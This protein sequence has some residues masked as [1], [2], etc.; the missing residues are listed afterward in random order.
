M[1]DNSPSN[2]MV[3]EVTRK[4]TTVESPSK[5]RISDILGDVPL[6]RNEKCPVMT[7]SGRIVKSPAKYHDF[8]E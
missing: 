1:N 5:C 2:T 6:E 3:T 8:V 4:E 7:R